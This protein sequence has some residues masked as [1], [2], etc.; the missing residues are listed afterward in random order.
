[1]LVLR[2][3]HNAKIQSVGRMYNLLMLNVS[4]I[5]IRWIYNS[6][7]FFCGKQNDHTKNRFVQGLDQKRINAKFGNM[8]AK[9]GNMREKF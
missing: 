2:Y 6:N 9:L 8:K 4:C 1:M 3:I 7:M 5:K